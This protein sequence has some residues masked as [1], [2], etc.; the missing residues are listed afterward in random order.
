M[1]H[2]DLPAGVRPWC[3]SFG[4]TECE[5]CHERPIAEYGPHVHLRF[6]WRPGKPDVICEFCWA[7]M[8]AAAAATL[9]A[10]IR[11]ETG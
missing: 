3:C 10:P 6:S 8:A 2:P 9:T 7:T 1:S 11:G 4:R 5:S